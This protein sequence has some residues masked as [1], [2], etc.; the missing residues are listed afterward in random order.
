[1]HR[2]TGLAATVLTL[3]VAATSIGCSSSGT[4]STAT[5]AT[6]GEGASQAA[7]RGSGLASALDLIP[8]IH[9]GSVM[10]S[11][12]SMV[13]HR[14]Q[15]DPNTASFAGSLVATDTLLQQQS[16]LDIKPADVQWELD[17][18]WPSGAP[19]I[20]L[21]FAPRTDLSGLAGNLTRRG[22][23]ADG[24]SLFT[25]SLATERL[26]GLS[27]IGIDARRHLLA[28]SGDVTR[29][30]SVLTAP[31]RP[32]A[33]ASEVVPLLALAAARLG[34]IATAAIAIGPAACVTMAEL[35]GLHAT[36]AQL[37][38]MRQFFHGTFTPPQA[39]ITALAG[40][41]GT[42]ALDALTF[43]DQR[44][45]AANRASRSAASEVAAGMR[46]G[47]SAPVTVTGT[48]V[49]GRVLSFDMTAAQPHD[50]PELV[51]YSDLG[52]DVCP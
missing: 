48:A 51:D 1:M 26:Y 19:L 47:G 12:W 27:N 41:A 18:L 21:G 46:F 29:L 24:P 8:D 2:A 52:V 25:G 34:R 4:F 9:D 5:S 13:G 7:I 50:F 30:R 45:A 39:E 43:P 16:A 14:D 6:G 22:F 49:T 23:H 3:A 17:V 38:R 31:A 35:L 33:N 10:Y 36:R 44:T 40:P 42:T 11:D 32:L 15:N 20:V 37:A 28:E